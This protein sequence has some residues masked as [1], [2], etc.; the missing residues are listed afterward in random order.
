MDRRLLRSE[1]RK[2]DDVLRFQGLSVWRALG[3]RVRLSSVS[4]LRANAEAAHAAGEDSRGK[5]EGGESDVPR[6]WTSRSGAHLSTRVYAD[7]SS[8]KCRSEH[9]RR[10]THAVTQWGGSDRVAP[11]TPGITQTRNT[12]SAVFADFPAVNA[13]T[14]RILSHR[15][16][17]TEHGATRRHTQLTLT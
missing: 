6:A 15:Q 12:S 7:G 8:R 16:D 14:T 1:C 9:K 11:S 17:T 4:Y 3:E 13:S 2:Q 5:R 10:R